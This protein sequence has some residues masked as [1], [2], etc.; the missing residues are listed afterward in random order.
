MKTLSILFQGITQTHNDGYLK[1]LEA[2]KK[3]LNF[4]Q[5][6]KF[7]KIPYIVHASIEW[8]LEKLHTWDTDP[9]KTFT[10]K[11]NK[12]MQCRC[13]LFTHTIHLITT[14][15]RFLKRWR[16]YKKALCKLLKK[17]HRNDQLWGKVNAIRTKKQET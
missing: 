7:L 2:W 10:S 16:L 17:L 1:M 6:H 5:N 3:I 12:H 9:I 11:I 8:L 4:T 13:S 15:G 14:K